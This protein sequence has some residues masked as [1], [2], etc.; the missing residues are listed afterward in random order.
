MDTFT[1]TSDPVSS[2]NYFQTLPPPIVLRLTE[3]L[4]KQNI[5][6]SCLDYIY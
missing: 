1:L 4:F 6:Y 5:G 3:A 2:R